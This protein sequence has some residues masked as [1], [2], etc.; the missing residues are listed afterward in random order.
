VIGVILTVLIYLALMV[1]VLFVMYR[2]ILHIHLNGRMLDVYHRVLGDE[3]A[4]FVPQVRTPLLLGRCM[5]SADQ[6]PLGSR[7]V[8]RRGPVDLR[9]CGTVARSQRRAVCPAPVLCVR[10]ADDGVRTQAQDVPVRG[11]RDRPAGA[12]VPRADRAHRCVRARAA[13]RPC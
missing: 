4:F 13:S 8:H 6:S 3:S 1:V 2:Y 11:R 12:I 9:A 10:P 7:A 5:R